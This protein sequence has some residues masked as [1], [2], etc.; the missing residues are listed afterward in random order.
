MLLPLLPIHAA[1]LVLGTSGAGEPVETAADPVTIHLYDEN[2][3]EYADV[4]IARDGSVDA[5]NDKKIRHLLRCKRTERQHKMNQGTLAM[6]AAVAARWPGHTIELVSGYRAMR[7][8]SSTSPHRAARAIDFRIRDVSAVAVRDYMWETFRHVGVG[9]YPE[10]QFLHLDH[11]PDLHDTAWTFRHGVNHYRP[12]WAERI[13]PAF[14]DA[15]AHPH[16]RGRRE[17]RHAAG[18]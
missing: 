2:H 13:R 15:P 11:R 8:E 6:F 4:T 9:W 12:S 7:R 1:L 17:R 10:E 14:E 16:P 18:V 5:E 3:R